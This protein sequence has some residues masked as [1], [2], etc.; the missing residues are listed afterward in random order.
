M[1]RNARP[2]HAGLGSAR[3]SASCSTTRRVV[4]GRLWKEDDPAEVVGAPPTCRPSPPSRCVR[5]ARSSGD[6]RIFREH[7]LP[8]TVVAQ[9]SSAILRLVGRWSTRG[10]GGG[11]P[12][13]LDRLPRCGRRGRVRRHGRC[14]IDTIQRESA[15]RPVGWVQPGPR[16]WLGTPE[17][18]VK[19]GGLLYDSDADELPLLGRGRGAPGAPGHP[20]RVARAQRLPSSIPNGFATAGDFHDYLVDPFER[21]YEGSGPD[22]VGG[23]HCLIVGRPGW[24]RGA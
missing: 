4:S 6:S 3:P 9:A 14:V 15:M 10:P 8:R 17:S 11:Q 20:V 22:D 19:E 13:W 16:L 12:W 18:V 23:L 2:T 5:S 21:L 7:D 24:C 1:G